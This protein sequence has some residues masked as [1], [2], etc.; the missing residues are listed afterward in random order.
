[1]SAEKATNTITTDVRTTI[2]VELLDEGVFVMRPVQGRR[3]SENVYV[4]LPTVNYDPEVEAWRFEP[5]S[6]VECSWEEYEGEILLVATKLLERGTS[7][8]HSR[9]VR[10]GP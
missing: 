10:A 4:I 2:Y 3:L 1:M 8:G 9:S 5:G 6:K 7:G